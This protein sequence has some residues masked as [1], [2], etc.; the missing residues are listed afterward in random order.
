ML[1]AAA[2][3]VCMANGRPIVKECAD[4][5]TEHDNNHDG[6]VEIIDKFIL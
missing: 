4:V 3:G 1:E 5:I 6:I 2:V